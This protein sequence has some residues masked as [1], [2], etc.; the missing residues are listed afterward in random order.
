MSGQASFEKRILQGVEYVLPDHWIPPPKVV[1]VCKENEAFK[2]ACEKLVED[3]RNN[4]NEV[5]LHTALLR[6]QENFFSSL[7]M[8][9]KSCLRHMFSDQIICL[10]ATYKTS[11]FSLYEMRLKL[12]PIRLREEPPPPAQVTNIIRYE[13]FALGEKIDL[14]EVKA[15]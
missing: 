1:P 3:T 7:K 8:A 9:P 4:L 6:L 10:M 2:V 5:T 15:P 13:G 11:F 14:Q 12:N